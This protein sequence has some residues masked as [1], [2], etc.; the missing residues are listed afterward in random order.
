MASSSRILYLCL[1]QDLLTE[2]PAQVLGRAKIDLPSAQQHR[3][4]PFHARDPEEAGHP[5]GFKLDQQV[6]V[7]VGTKIS[8]ERRTEN[9]QSLDAMLTAKCSYGVLGY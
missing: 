2:I 8:T 9:R 3:K 1:F 4:L 5:V 7:A 6:D